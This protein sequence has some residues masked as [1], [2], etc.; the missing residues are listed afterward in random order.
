MTFTIYRLYDADDRLLYVGQSA[1]VL[2]RL[3]HHLGAGYVRRIARVE[4]EH[5]PEGS[6]RAD[7][8]TAERI[9]IIAG[10]PRWNVRSTRLAEGPVVA[11]VIPDGVETVTIA[12]AATLTDRPHQSLVALVCVH[13]KARHW[14]RQDGRVVVAVEDLAELHRAP[15]ER[16][17]ADDATPARN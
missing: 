1:V 13:G 12:E 17:L 6:D 5:L 3:G 2:S 8:L 14:R 10:Q 4:L 7:A 11:D 16:F 9:A 15:G